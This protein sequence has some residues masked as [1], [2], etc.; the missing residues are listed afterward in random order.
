MTKHGIVPIR[1]LWSDG[2]LIFFTDT[3]GQ[4]HDATGDLIRDGKTLVLGNR[5][6]G[7]LEIPR[8]CILW[9]ET[10]E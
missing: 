2:R 9:E 5:Q 10:I 1:E 4:I 8:Q 7:R 6:G 3:S